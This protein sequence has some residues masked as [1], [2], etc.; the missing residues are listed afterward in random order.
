MSAWPGHRPITRTRMLGILERAVAGRNDFSLDERA[1]CTA[2]EFW[3]SVAAGVL[4]AHLRTN[5]VDRLRSAA[6]V[7]S[8][9]GASHFAR[10]LDNALADLCYVQTSR[11]R[12]L[13][14]KLLEQQLRESTDRVDQLLAQF[15]ETVSSPGASEARVLHARRQRL[16][17]VVALHG[18]E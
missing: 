5:A 2:C 10:L 9:I 6:V 14:L 17:A 11:E 1:L 3:A 15:A 4:C 8:A 13:R 18:V 7:Y 16:R 12:Q